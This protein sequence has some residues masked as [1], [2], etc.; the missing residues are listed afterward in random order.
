MSTAR[1]RRARTVVSIGALALIGGM[2]TAT[3]AVATTPP[4]ETTEAAP[5]GS[6]PSGSSAPAEI[7]PIAVT[8]TA[9]SIDGL[10]TDLVAGLVEVSI[11]AEEPGVEVDFSRVEP[12]T[13]P[14]AFVEA[15]GAVM[16]G[17]PFPDFFLGNAGAV[18]GTIT[19]LDEG[20]YIVWFGEEEIV[21]VPMTVGAGDDDAV[22]PAQ[23]SGSLRAGDYLFDVDAVAGG[24]MATFTN[25]SDNQ[26]HHVVLMDFGSNDPALVEANLPAFLQ[27]EDETMPEGIDAA[28]VNPE[29]AGSPVYGPGGS[30]TFPVTFEE[31]HTY[32]ALCFISD[33]E[34]GLPHAIQHGMYDVFQVGAAG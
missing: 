17:A 11:T 5:T 32:V 26:F 9:T 34:G 10:P 1:A 22:V 16:E 12:G 19:A 29:F 4:E 33:R 6:A 25:S 15:L 21:A 13:D 30:G 31:G 23:D 3:N 7:Q 2:M 27:S 20:E 8:L 14:A 24:S 28:Q 18:N